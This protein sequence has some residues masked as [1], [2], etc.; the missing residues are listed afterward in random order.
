MPRRR[1][2]ERYTAESLVRYGCLLALG[3]VAGLVAMVVSGEARFAI[4]VL[5]AFAFLGVFALKPRP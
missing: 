4:A 3:I 1:P 2:S 5:A